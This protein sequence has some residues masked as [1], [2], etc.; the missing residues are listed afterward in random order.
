MTIPRITTKTLCDV[1]GASRSSA[2]RESKPR[3]RFYRRQKDEV[4]LEQIKQVIRERASY[5]HRRVTRLV[6]HDF[7]AG[8]NKKRIRRVMKM[9]NLQLPT[10][11]RRRSG[12]PHLGRI[13]R[14]GSNERWCSDALEIRCWNGDMVQIA[15][16]LDCHD[17]EA[18]SFV[19][20]PRVLQ[21]K[22]IQWLMRD[23]V[24]SRFEDGKTTVP[25]QWLSDNGG[26]YTALETVIVAE[27]LGLEPITTPAYSP[28]SNGMSEAF[29]NTLKRDYVECAMLCDAQTVLLQVPGWLEDYNQRAPHSALGML[30]P[31]QY[32]EK[33]QHQEGLTES[34]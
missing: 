9:H 19:A 34:L 7:D 4:V 10:K 23:A 1:L 22:D 5:G 30:S 16:A 15:F 29:V 14:D 24:C 31:R 17:R 2:Y 33:Y 20:Q 32:R 11:N 12:R 18:L 13:I 26:I 27:E 3:P 21:A 6:N 25:V 8:Y 28:Q